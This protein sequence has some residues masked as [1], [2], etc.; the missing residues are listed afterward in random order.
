MSNTVN[1]SLSFLY[2]PITK[3][4]DGDIKSLKDLRQALKARKHK[5]KFF[6]FLKDCF[7]KEVEFYN[8]NF[9]YWKDGIDSIVAVC[10]LRSLS[11]FSVISFEFSKKWRIV[12]AIN[13]LSFD[14]ATRCAYGQASTKVETTRGILH[15]YSCHVVK[16]ELAKP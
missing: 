14:D 7:T 13:S 6:L 2:H 10:K 4:L 16:M 8:I 5:N 11:D 12:N 15:D 1:C 3:F 9:V